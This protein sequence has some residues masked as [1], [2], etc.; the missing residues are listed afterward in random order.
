MTNK[1]Y[2][3]DLETYSESAA[4]QQLLQA[5]YAAADEEMKLFDDACAGK[6]VPFGQFTITIGGV[7]TA[8]LLGGAQ[9]EA[10]AAFIDYLAKENGYAVDF[11]KA[12]VTDNR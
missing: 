3:I 8:F 1:N 12:T 5:A 7:Q 10:L 9:I 11:N 2:D 6:D 4:L